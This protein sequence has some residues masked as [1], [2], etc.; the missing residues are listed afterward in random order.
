MTDARGS[1]VEKLQEKYQGIEVYDTSVTIKKGKHGKLTGDATGSLVQGID[2]DLPDLTPTLTDE[3]SV[4]IAAKAEGDD[5]SE[6]GDVTIKR[7]IY[8]DK[9]NTARLVNVISYLQDG[10]KKPYY[11]VDLKDGTIL[12]KWQGL[13]TYPC[14]DRTKYGIGGNEKMGKIQYGK[15]P[16]C[17]TPERVG[18]RCYLENKYVRVVDM[19]YTMNETIEETASFECTEGYGDEVNGAYSPALDAFFYGTLVG[20]LFEE[21]FDSTPLTDKIILRVHYGDHYP[22]AFWN[23][24]NCTFGDGWYDMYPFTTL[25]VVAHEI[26]HGI[27]EQASALEYFFE[28]GG[29]NE[30]FADIMGEC[31]EEYLL[32]S[33]MVTGQYVMKYLPFMRDFKRPDVDN[34]SISH[35]S[36]ME[37][38]T[39]PH[40]SSGIYRRVWYVLV[41]DFEMEFR[42]AASVFVFANRMYWHSSAT[43]YDVSCGLLMAA[44]DLGIDTFPFYMAFHDVGIQ[45][46]DV[47]RHVFSVNNNETQEAVKVGHSV[48]P[49]FRFD[50]PG[51]AEKLTVVVEPTSTKH[52]AS[53]CDMCEY[54]SPPVLITVMTGGWEQSNDTCDKSGGTVVA[55][56]SSPLVVPNAQNVEFFVKLSVDHDL[57]GL[58]STGFDSSSILVDLTIGYTC[59]EDYYADSYVEGYYYSEICGF[60]HSYY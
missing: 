6:L 45:E 52:N 31:A 39:D 5:V 3:E 47:S 15:M 14:H 22:N 8:V 55:K 9:K 36:D 30:A 17:M 38:W 32:K 58:N 26:G 43:F 11:I 16:Y 49:V 35:V 10:I 41:K 24:V 4:A 46:C 2:E 48:N 12:K 19:Q 44:L 50:S 13:T 54:G 42:D 60:E 57:Y 51:W 25:D 20:S 37:D 18:D 21:W 7:R 1:T 33:D 40:Y 34:S 23:G 53:M 56:G 28:Q 59:M 29:V 27:I